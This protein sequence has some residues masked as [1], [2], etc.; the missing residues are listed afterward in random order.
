MQNVISKIQSATIRS[1]AIFLAL[2]ISVAVVS[3]H[4]DDNNSSTSGATTNFNR[5]N[6]V[7]NNS[8]DSGARVDPNLVNGWGIAFSPTGNPW[9]SSE[10]GGVS[11][12]YDATGNQV[13]PPVSIPSA[14]A[15]TGGHPTGT[16]FNNSATAF[17][18]P[19]G[20]VAKFIFVGDDGVISGWSSG[21]AAERV[22]DNSASASYTGVTIANDSAR[23]FLY[24]ANFK[25]ARIDVFDSSFTAV[26]KT[27]TDP[28]LP[29]GYSPFNIQNVGGQLYVMY[30]KLGS[31]GDEEKGAGLGYVDIFKPD[32]S[33]VGRFASQGSLNAPWGIAMAPAGFLDGNNSNVILIGN[34]G[35]GQINAYSPDA[36]FIGQLKSNGTPV[37]IDGLWGISF[38]PSSAS[39]IPPTRLFF[40]A[41]P[42]D[43]QN[44]LFGYIDR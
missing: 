17:V 22:V 23:T 2:I 34:F 35:D 32:G 33:L 3:C 5:V 41:G 27:F 19:G 14:S 25:Q 24:A 8:Q 29:E 7:S 42:N 1:K 11:V 13:V 18:L 36:K 16:V 15:N 44:G 26:S 12:A 6:L 4:K 39:N 37:V 10:G 31:N 30:A 28:G 38:A 21:T 9:L 40:A 20:G 43:E